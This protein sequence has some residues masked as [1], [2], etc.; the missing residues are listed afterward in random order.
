VQSH[1]HAHLG[2]IGPIVLGQSSLRDD[3]G[4]Q[5]RVGAGEGE[6]ER[7]SLVVDLA[8][9]AFLCGCSKDATLLG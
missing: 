8:A 9:F 4:S 1:P 2:A 6:E 5:G 7:V 3:R